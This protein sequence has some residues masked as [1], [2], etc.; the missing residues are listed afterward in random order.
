MYHSKLIHRDKKYNLTFVWGENVITE[1]FSLPRFRL[2]EAVVPGEA[3]DW[4]CNQIKQTWSENRVFA[5]LFLLWWRS[6]VEEARLAPWRH[7]RAP[8]TRKR[9]ELF[10]VWLKLAV[11]MTKWECE[12]TVHHRYWSATLKMSESDKEKVRA[13]GLEESGR[14]RSFCVH[15]FRIAG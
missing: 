2:T 8:D 14:L 10:H 6:V 13:V 15:R 1:Q 12:L 9:R 11:F 4:T 3:E 7:Q 5:P